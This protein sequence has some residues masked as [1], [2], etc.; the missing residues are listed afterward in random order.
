MPKVGE[1]WR[2]RRDGETI[3]L[4]SI[5][6]DNPLPECDCDASC[7]GTVLIEGDG[8]IGWNEP[9]GYKINTALDEN[10]EYHPVYNSPLYK[11]IT[12]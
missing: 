1:V 2:D 3:R 10:W 7:L 9:L 5:C 11:A 8:S 6:C 4:L 12:G